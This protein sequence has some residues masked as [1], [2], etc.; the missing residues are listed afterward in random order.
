MTISSGKWKKYQLMK[1]KQELSAHLPDTYLLNEK[2]FWHSI[3]RYGSI[4]IK[5]TKGYM[6]KGIVQVASKGND[7]YE[8]HVLEKRYTV[9]GRKHTFEHLMK[10]H[11]LKK[12]Y[13]VQQKIPLA[14]FKKSPYDLRV[15]V[16]RMKNQRDWTVTGKMA[17]VAAKGLVLTNYPK[18]LITAED[19]VNHSSFKTPSSYILEEIDRISILAAEHLSNY[20]TNTRI[21]GL[22]IGL[23]DQ[24]D[25]W[26]IEANLAPS[27][28]IFKA[29]KD[30]EAYKRIVKYRKG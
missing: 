12:H 15:M 24:A 14:T 22:D 25:I 7:L 2:T 28:S 3:D 21:F 10:H 5:P 27:I 16:Q 29:L 17:K 6:G 30:D 8:F 26:I 20:Y 23:D 4:M 11:C 13:I 18:Y 9:E 19:A 1:K